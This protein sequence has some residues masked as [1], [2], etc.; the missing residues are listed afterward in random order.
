MQRTYIKSGKAIKHLKS[1]QNAW[2]IY[3]NKII[4]KKKS[5]LLN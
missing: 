3:L 1:I 5:K 2:K 4:N